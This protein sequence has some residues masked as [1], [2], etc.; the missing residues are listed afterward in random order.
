[1]QRDVVLKGLHR[2]HISGVYLYN[3]AAMSI[4]PKQA[5][6]LNREVYISNRLIITTL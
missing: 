4:V 2:F 6:L 1:M 3:L 5:A